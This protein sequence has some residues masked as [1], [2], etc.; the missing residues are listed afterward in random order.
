MTHSIETICLPT[1][2]KFDVIKIDDTE[3]TPP[4]INILSGKYYATKAKFMESGPTFTKAF[5]YPEDE[6]TINIDLYRVENA[7]FDPDENPITYELFSARTHVAPNVLWFQP[8]NKSGQSIE[9]SLTIGLKIIQNELDGI[10]VPLPN[11]TED[12]TTNNSFYLQGSV[13]ISKV[14]SFIPSEDKPA[15]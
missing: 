1:F 5:L 7:T 2:H 15:S 14:N 3:K 13:Q 9:L 8:Y 6:S 4:A 10:I 11:L 12:L